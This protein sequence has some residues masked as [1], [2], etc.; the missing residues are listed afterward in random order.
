MGPRTRRL[1]TAAG[2]PEQLIAGQRFTVYETNQRL[3]GKKPQWHAVSPVAGREKMSWIPAVCADIAQPVG[4]L[5]EK[6]LPAGIAFF[7]SH[8]ICIRL[9]PPSM[10]WIGRL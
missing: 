3:R 8:V 2:G 5:G 7:Q 1:V 4:G 6:A 10:F 9:S